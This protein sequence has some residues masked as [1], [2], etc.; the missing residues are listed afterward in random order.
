MCQQHVRVRRLW[1]L[2]VRV[3]ETYGEGSYSRRPI[4]TLRLWQYSDGSTR[5][6]GTAVQN[7]TPSPLRPEIVIVTMCGRR[8]V[9]IAISADDWAGY[10]QRTSMHSSATTLASSSASP[11]Q[12]LR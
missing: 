11:V 10:Q 3:Y 4:A 2:I 6:R 8:V 7:V 5:I 9:D 12:T 1:S